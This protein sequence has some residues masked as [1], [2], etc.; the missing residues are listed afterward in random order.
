M[1][2]CP[3]RARP[4]LR[5]GPLP[6]PFPAWSFPGRPLL[7]PVPAWTQALGPAGRTWPGP[8]ACSLPSPAHSL[9]R[10][11]L[12]PGIEPGPMGQLKGP[13]NVAQAKCLGGSRA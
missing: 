6:G 9:A 1:F 7:G 4:G 8:A 5:P 11:D 10:P 3:S 2:E 12:G 13:D